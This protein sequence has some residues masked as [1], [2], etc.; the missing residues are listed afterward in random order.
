MVVV[1]VRGLW[2][3]VATHTHA[4]GQGALHEAVG[5]AQPG[6]R[7]GYGVGVVHVPGVILHVLLGDRAHVRGHG[8]GLL[9][10]WA[11]SGGRGRRHRSAGCTRW[12]QP[13]LLR[14][15]L[16]Q[17]AGEVVSA[18]KTLSTA[19]AKEVTAPSV[20][21]SVTPDILTRVKTAVTSLT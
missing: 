2:G 21:H 5:V 8:A 13:R 1:W 14:V 18:A 15:T 10:H 12:Y 20:H 7:T 9:L 4:R 19:R 6:N 3:H 16:L 11:L 17:V